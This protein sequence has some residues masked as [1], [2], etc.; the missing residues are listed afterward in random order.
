VSLALLTRE[1]NTRESRPGGSPSLS[2]PSCDFCGKSL[3]R[4][5]RPRL[6]W[7]SQPATELILADLC[8]G[9]ATEAESLVDRCG[10]HGRAAIALVDEALPARPHR[11]FIPIERGALYVFVGLTFFLIV[12]LLSSLI[13]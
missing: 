9:C 4:S 7:R 12:T 1:P 2:T 6:V 8:R 3:V 5:E 13:R 11:L 10:G